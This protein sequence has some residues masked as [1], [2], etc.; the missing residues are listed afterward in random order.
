[1]RSSTI[2]LGATLL[3]AVLCAN[4]VRAAEV[5]LPVP[6][7]M[8]ALAST[9]ADDN[10][11][12]DDDKDESGG[13]RESGEPGAD[14]ASR[15]ACSAARSLVSE[16][17]S[18]GI[19]GLAFVTTTGPRSALSFCEALWR[20][21]SVGCRTDAGRAVRSWSRSLPRSLR[22]HVDRGAGLGCAPCNVSALCFRSW[23]SRF[24]S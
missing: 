22:E 1:V 14:R 24:V 18:G 20:V 23:R 4:A 11:N 2:A 7:A 5:P 15:R 12:D 9:P 13:A 17:V 10:N 3:V 16:V 8:G 19:S 21:A 6:P